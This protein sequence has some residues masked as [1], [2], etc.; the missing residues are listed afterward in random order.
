MKQLFI[1]SI[2]IFTCLTTQAQTIA[3]VNKRVDSTVTALKAIVARFDSINKRQS[4]SLALI[5]NR[6]ANF[7]GDL[8]AARA[9]LLTA[10]DSIQKLTVQLKLTTDTLNLTRKNLDTLKAVYSTVAIDLVNGLWGLDATNKP[11]P[12][13]PFYDAVNK[14]VADKLKTLTITIQ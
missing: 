8:K 14:A 11:I 13:Q 12:L 1:L 2:F 10:R 4:D 7:T 6:T 5:A 3:S 9:D